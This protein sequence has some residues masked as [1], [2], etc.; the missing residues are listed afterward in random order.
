MGMTLLHFAAMNPKPNNTEILTFLIEKGFNVNAVAG[1]NTT[2]LDYAA[3]TGEN[4][5]QAEYILTY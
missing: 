5:I 3:S 1:D 2:T 4:I